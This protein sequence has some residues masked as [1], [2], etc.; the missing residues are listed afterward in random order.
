MRNK[1][2]GAIQKSMTEL[3]KNISIDSNLSIG[4]ESDLSIDLSSICLHCGGT[5]RLRAMQS[6]MV[7][8]GSSVRGPD[9]TAKCNFCNGTGRR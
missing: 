6:M 8:G 7:M 9:T 2:N 3:P 1:S 5:G 4:V